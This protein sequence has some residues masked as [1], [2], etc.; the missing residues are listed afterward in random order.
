MKILQILGSLSAGDAIGNDA[1]AVKHVIEDMG[2]KTA[3]YSPAVSQKIKE[4]GVYTLD[5]MP[6][7]SED[8]IVIYHMGSGSPVNNMVADLNCR[9]IMRYHNITPFEFFS[10]DSP[11]AAEDCRRGIINMRQDLVGRFT[12]YIAVSEFNKRDMIEMGY[13]ERDIEVI[14]IMFP[15]DDYKQAPD[16]RMVKKLS[17]GCT[18]IVFV[19]RI[20]PNKKHEDLIRAFAYYKKHVNAKSRLILAGSP[21]PDGIYFGDL[22]AYIKKLGVEDVVF[23]GHISFPEILAIYKTADVFFCLSEH[24]GFCVPLLEAMTFDVPIVAYDACAVPETLGGSGIVVDDKDP[25]FLSRVLDE[26]CTNEDLRKSVIAAQRER[27]KDFAYEKIKAQLQDYLRRFME[28]YPPLS[29][30]DPKA[31]YKKLYEL[32]EENMQKAGK[33]L[34]FS[35]EALLACAEREAEDTD[36]T[37]LLNR[38]CTDSEFIEAAYIA[39]FNM[40]PD[41]EARSRWEEKARSLSRAELARAIV[42]EAVPSKTRRDKGT[43]VRYDPFTAAVRE[44]AGGEGG[45]QTA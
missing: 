34:D 21:N 9:K 25:A 29:P 38:S 14:P 19:G 40:L 10:I 45:A 1:I 44:A 13:K 41:S 28:N 5:S 37:A 24:E 32:T 18:N 3:I 6:K 35:A 2:I 39:F 23:P 8:D 30:D 11:K 12:A 4:K 42:E 20:A 33:A 15:F 17:D 26:V 27:M 22:Q 36:V 16:S 31:A 7:L 43:K